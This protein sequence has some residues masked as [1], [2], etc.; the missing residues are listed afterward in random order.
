MSFTILLLSRDAGP[1]WP[2]KISRAVPGAVAKACADPEVAIADIETGD[3]AYRT[4]PPERFARAKKAAL[5]LCV[6]RRKSA[7]RIGLGG[8]GS[9][10]LI[11]SDIVVTGR[12]GRYNEHLIHAVG[13][14]FAFARHFEH[15][16]PQ[17]CWQRGPGM[18]D[19][20]EQ[21]VL[22][23]EPRGSRRSRPPADRQLL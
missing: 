22:I 15:Y 10:M 4:A 8:T 19:L 3:A 23:A 5:D 7:S 9:T 11:Q 12:H 18:I 14:L 20:P 6:P 21:T 17:K 13:L 2:E 1:S 16:L